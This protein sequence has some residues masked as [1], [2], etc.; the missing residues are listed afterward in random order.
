MLKKRPLREAREPPPPTPN[1]YLFGSLNA[2]LFSLH[3]LFESII[4]QAIDVLERTLDDGFG[5]S[6]EPKEYIRIYT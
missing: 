3:S 2:S 1:F 6:F 5:T 4:V